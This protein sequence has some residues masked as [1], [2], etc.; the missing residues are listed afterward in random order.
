[1]IISHTAEWLVNESEELAAGVMTHHLPINKE[2]P[3]SPQGTHI[4]SH[5]SLSKGSAIFNDMRLL[6]GI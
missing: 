3:V 6:R 2:R 4:A 1:M 5:L